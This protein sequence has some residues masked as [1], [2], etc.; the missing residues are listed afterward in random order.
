MGDEQFH[1]SRKNRAGRRLQRATR[2][3][4]CSGGPTGHGNADES[5]RHRRAGPASRPR[6]LGFARRGRTASERSNRCSLGTTRTGVTRFAVHH[7]KGIIVTITPTGDPSATGGAD[8]A[9]S[10]AETEAAL[11][12]LG[13]ALRCVEQALTSL[14]EVMDELSRLNEDVHHGQA[15]VPGEQPDVRVDGHNLTRQEQRVLTLVAAGLPNRRIAECLGISD[16]T[17][18][19]YVHT[20]LVKL[21][22]STRTEAA[23][24]ALSGL[25]VDPEECRRARLSGSSSGM[26]ALRGL[27][28]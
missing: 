16:K 28:R 17:A 12:V 15:G 24:K 1:T 18:K 4:P 22:V 21:D 6:P 2:W 25:L 10:P 9:A 23:S 7:T 11:A 3:S 20:V 27:D 19:N 26:A 5:A 8:H 14:A 13:R